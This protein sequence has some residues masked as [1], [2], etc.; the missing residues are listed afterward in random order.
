MK[1][2]IVRKEVAE[3]IDSIKQHS[4]E[5]GY[6]KRIPQLELELM[7]NK[8]KKLY[9]KSIIYNY[10]NS[11]ENE[12]ND[13]PHVIEK[14]KNA[15]AVTI[16]KPESEIPHPI[17]IPSASKVEIP[18]SP[19]VEI[20]ATPK[21]ESRPATHGSLVKSIRQGIGLNE[22]IMFIKQLFNGDSVMYESVITELENAQS[23]PEAQQILDRHKDHY[24]WMADNPSY[25]V[26][27]QLVKRRFSA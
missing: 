26:L 8:I 23:V 12:L 1:K 27:Q 11:I 7:L 24:R 5:I 9:E 3:L 4:D 10:L 15:P 16:Q 21:P 19:K 17:E 25:H 2:N 14:D 18:V 6:Q 13:R 22:K 20:P